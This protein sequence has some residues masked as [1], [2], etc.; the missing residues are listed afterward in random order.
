MNERHCTVFDNRVRN[1]ATL[2]N[3]VLEVALGSLEAGADVGRLLVGGAGGQ[4]GGE[5]GLS[6]IKKESKMALVRRMKT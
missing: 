2:T 6:G 3:R 4:L 5:L 1:V